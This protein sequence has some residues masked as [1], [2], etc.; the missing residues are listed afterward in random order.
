MATRDYW[1]VFGSGNPATNTGLAPTFIKFVDGSGGSTT[2][3][4]IAETPAGSG[5]YKASYQPNGT[6]AFILDGATT[7]L[8]ASDRYISGVLDPYDLFGVTLNAIGVTLTA[9]GATIVAFGGTLTA[10]GTNVSAV[11]TTLTAQGSTLVGAGNT[12]GAIGVSLA[13]MSA[14]LIAQG[15]T[16]VGNGTT[17]AAFAAAQG[18]SMAA[19]GSTLNAIGTSL[20]AFETGGATLVGIG[21]TIAAMSVLLGTQTSAYGSTASD[22]TTVFGF[23]IRAQELAEGN[24]VY[25]KSTGVFQMFTRGATLL[26]QKTI[27]DTSSQTTKT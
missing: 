27:S 3:P 12:L 9:Q 20:A 10:I 25:T 22:P 1:F 18:V 16:V 4:A 11:G 26:R 15:A 17:L 21:N 8:V 7:G 19:M 14:T 5:L 23:L 6:V 2:P 24:Q 13:A